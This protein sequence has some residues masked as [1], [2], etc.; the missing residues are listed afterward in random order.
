MIKKKSYFLIFMLVSLILTSCGKIIEFQ[1]G[2]ETASNRDT[3]NESSYNFESEDI[4]TD[5]LLNENEIGYEAE[6][7]ILS[8]CAYTVTANP[9]LWEYSYD[10]QDGHRFMSRLTA[11]K[12]NDEHISYYDHIIINDFDLEQLKEITGDQ[13]NSLDTYVDEL[14]QIGKENGE[15]FEYI[16]DTFLG[17]DCVLI[18]YSDSEIISQSIIFQNNASIICIKY[19]ANRDNFDVMQAK[20]DEVIETFKMRS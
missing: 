11:N 18:N 17:S 6:T 15:N 1:N 16:K 3:E 8:T 4:T 7:G 14:K 20:F 12:E 13:I 5:S 10:P 9:D 19:S 2:T